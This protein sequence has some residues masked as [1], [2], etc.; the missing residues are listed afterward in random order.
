MAVMVV[1]V[2]GG[3][4]VVESSHGTFSALYP[5][6]LYQASNTSQVS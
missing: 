5:R 1:V 2:V 6:P 3:G 4:E